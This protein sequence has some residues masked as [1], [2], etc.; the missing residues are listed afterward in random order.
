MRANCNC[1]SSCLNRGAERRRLASEFFVPGVFWC[2]GFGALRLLG[3]GDLPWEENGRGVPL[4]LD[5]VD[6][7]LGRLTSSTESRNIGCWSPYS[8]PDRSRPGK[9]ISTWGCNR[10]R[11]ALS[12]P[13]YSK[14]WECSNSLF[15]KETPAFAIFRCEESNEAQK[16]RSRDSSC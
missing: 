10:E 14:R 9:I 1:E 3:S 12:G 11:A 2:L 6:V 15:H 16:K 5:V 13:V 7:S 4:L 8:P